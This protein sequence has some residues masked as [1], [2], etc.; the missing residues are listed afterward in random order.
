MVYA[1]R[2]FHDASC[3]LKYLARYT[4]R[5]AISNS[6]LL[7]YQDGKVTFRY[8]DYAHE[9]QQ[10]TM[11]VSAAEFIR[12]FLLHVLPSGFMRI[13]HYGYLANRHRRE[14]L[15]ACRRLLGSPPDALTLCHRGAIR[16]RALRTGRRRGRED[17]PLP[18]VQDRTDADH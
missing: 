6:R 13:R 15:E 17:D 7:G 14:K 12:R 1:K 18:D 10:R 2:P 8:K 16:G 5:V 4:H 3:V 11:T 9:S